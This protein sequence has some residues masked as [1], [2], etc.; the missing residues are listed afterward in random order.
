MKIYYSS[1]IQETNTFCP[2]QTDL[3]LFQ[4]GYYYHG[5][6]IPQKLRGTNTEVGGFYQY[7]EEHPEVLSPGIACWAVA[8]GKV[9]E[10]VYQTIEKDILESLKK[11]LPVDGV[12]LA[13]HGA[14]VSEQRDDCEGAL[15]E[16]VRKLVGPKIPVVV[17]LDYHA[18]ITKKMVEYSDVLVGFRTYPHVD[19]AKTGI[20]AACILEELI[21]KKTSFSP[22]FHKLPLMVPVEDSETGKGI[23]GDVIKKLEEFDKEEDL[24]S[25]SLFCA[26]PW[27]DID[28]AGVSLLFY[29]KGEKEKWESRV[30]GLEQYI[31]ENKEAFFQ[32]YP[33]IHEVLT[34]METYEKPLIVVDSGDITTA[35]GIG[36]S[37]EILWALLEQKSIAK[38]ALSIVSPRAVKEAFLIGEG[39][40]GNITI[41]GDTDYGYN[42]SVTVYA[43]V[44]SL[45]DKPSK[46]NGEAFSGVEANSGRRAYLLIEEH[47]HAVV[48]EY[49][50]LLYDP[51][52]LRDLGIEP[53]EMDLIAQKSHK[54]FRSAYKDIAKEIVILNSPGFTDQNIKRLPFKKLQGVYPLSRD[55]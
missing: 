3:S 13:L 5:E 32:K 44:I 33:D 17:T 22:V 45:T 18:N 46:V 30:Q 40:E 21:Q 51:Q 10:E 9:K 41:G 52:F 25:A 7:F 24:L 36:D 43:R 27:L 11:R 19:F 2:V 49:T 35:G 1:L 54:L 48:T 26:Q 6:E 14:L 55:I 20:K 39:N 28:E 47:I 34:N 12:L 4:R 16:K 23:S 29:V 38:A 15:L 31:M 42:K 8:S 37:T 53:S 50:S